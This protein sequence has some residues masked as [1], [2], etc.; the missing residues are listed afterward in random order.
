M[1]CTNVEVFI[2]E[3]SAVPVMSCK[4]RTFTGFYRKTIHSSPGET[5]KISSG[6]PTAVQEFD[7]LCILILVCD[8]ENLQPLTSDLKRKCPHISRCQFEMID[9]PTQSIPVQFRNQ[10]KTTIMTI[11]ISAI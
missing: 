2:S 11:S 10:M 8:G 3:Q 7:S 4:I 1:I 5:G 9:P 6:K